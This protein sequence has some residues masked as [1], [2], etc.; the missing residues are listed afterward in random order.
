M[1]F[2]SCDGN[3][4][5]LARMNNMGWSKMNGLKKLFTMYIADVKCPIWEQQ[6]PACFTI[7]L[8]SRLKNLKKINAWQSD[9]MA[10]YWRQ[11]FLKDIFAAA[12][13]RPV[14]Q[15]QPSKTRLDLVLLPFVE[16]CKILFA[17]LPP[18]IQGSHI[19]TFVWKIRTENR[20]K[21]ERSSHQVI[22]PLRG[23][24]CMSGLPFNRRPYFIRI[25][26]CDKLLQKS[27][28]TMAWIGL[29]LSFAWSSYVVIVLPSERKE[30]LTFCQSMHVT[31]FAMHRPQ[32]LNLKLCD[33][34]G[35]GCPPPCWYM[36]QTGAWTGS[37]LGALNCV[38]A[39]W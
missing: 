18:R 6:C 35:E 4:S 27:T 28:H 22:L 15:L 24:K 31:T 5:S 38:E 39:T 20:R 34:A 8:T 2:L 21:E 16:D 11:A 3:H 30:W 29:S 17:G 32:N 14:L 9:W 37:A 12:S 25:T 7:R 36:Y 10:T 1:L 33:M 26:S 23:K 19:Y 13:W